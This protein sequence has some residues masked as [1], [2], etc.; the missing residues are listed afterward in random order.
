MFLL[1]LRKLDRAGILDLGE[2]SVVDAVR[3]QTRLSEETVRTG[4]EALFLNKT[5]L[6]RKDL[7]LLIAPNFTEA[8]ETKSSDRARK[9]AS[10]ERA[11]AHARVE[12]LG[13]TVRDL[14]SQNVT[15]SL[16]APHSG[17][18][19]NR[20]DQSQPVTG[21]TDPTVNE[22]SQSV[23]NRDHR[24]QNEP[25]GHNWSQP[26][27]LSLAEQS[28][29]EQS[30]ADQVKSKDQKRSSKQQASRARARGGLPAQDSKPPDQDPPKGLDR[31]HH[32]DEDFVDSTIPVPLTLYKP[33]P[34]LQAEAEASGI[35]RGE[36]HVTL[37]RYHERGR[38]EHASQ[39]AHDRAFKGFLKKSREFDKPSVAPSPRSNGREKTPHFMLPPEQRGELHP[40]DIAR[41][42]AKPPWHPDFKKKKTSSEDT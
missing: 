1:L 17:A 41:L 23:T 21:A 42:N 10:R 32:P 35:D 38:L 40:N 20:D 24:S 8:Q 27:T 14:L 28:L 36:L 11:R 25:K 7:K 13:V 19:T 29:A 26:V 9:R 18:V 31:D 16:E 4:L 37:E 15:D 2:H 39:R 5:L 30:L 34:W 12:Q 3:A 22:D 6:Y 33:S